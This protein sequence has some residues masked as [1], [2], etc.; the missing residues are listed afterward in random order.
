MVG[1]RPD[2]LEEFRRIV[3]DRR[4]VLGR[5]QRAVADELGISAA[6]LCQF[7]TGAASLSE[8]RRE[9]LCRTLELPWPPEATLDPPVGARVL[10]LCKDETC[11]QAV[12]DM[13]G[14]GVVDFQPILIRAAADRPTYCPACGKELCAGC[15]H[16]G[17]PLGE[18]AV[19]CLD[20]GKPYLRPMANMTVSDLRKRD[21]R[22]ERR[23][24]QGAIREHP[25]HRASMA[26]SDAPSASD[27]EGSGE[28]E[29]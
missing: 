24:V 2:A 6:A 23:R 12:G 25:D 22:R 29:T 14:K 8:G 10:K 27:E 28:S 7:E 20:C 13:N 16:C 17:Y 11:L 19:F 15:P 1:E 9:A 3:R 4:R 5:S 26:S 18:N 21:A